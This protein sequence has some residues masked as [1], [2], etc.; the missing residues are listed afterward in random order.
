MSRRCSCGATKKEEYEYCY[1]CF[2]HHAEADG[3][4][5]E[6]GALKGEE[7]EHCYSCAK[8]VRQEKR[9]QRGWV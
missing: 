3:R 5:C 6:C 4:I 9:R 7:Y 8:E 1:D 2:I